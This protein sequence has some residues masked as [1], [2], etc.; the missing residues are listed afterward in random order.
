MIDNTNIKY[1]NELKPGWVTVIVPTYNRENHIKGAI[2][3]VLDQTYPYWDII[4][5]DD[6]STD[7][8]A[9]AVRKFGEKRLT[10]HHILHSGL[11]GVARNVGIQMARGEYIAFLDSDDQWLEKKLKKQVAV[12]KEK[13]QLGMVCSNAFVN[14]E[15]RLS[16]YHD[17]ATA[18]GLLLR[19]LL[20]GSFIITSTVLVRRDLLKI[21]GLFPEMPALRA[22]EDYDLW[23]RIAAT[24]EL[25]YLPEALAI[26]RDQPAESIRHRV[27]QIAYWKGLNMIIT[28][29]EHYL[30]I[31]GKTVPGDRRQ[32]KR[33]R[34]MIM[35]MLFRLSRKSGDYRTSFR[36]CCLYIYALI[37][38]RMGI[39]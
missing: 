36:Y 22:M 20:Q 38:Y 18:Q 32:I 33:N 1:A 5:V 14:S 3:S 30:S 16:P 11:P 21:T 24:S 28:R 4:V 26:Y 25:L 31:M 39:F 23:L 6:G 29:L 7:D 9:S 35:R 34:A 12:M 17:K 37:R 15:G 27:S 19:E 8:T 10:Y 13:R 2:Q